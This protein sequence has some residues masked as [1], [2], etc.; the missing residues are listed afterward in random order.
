MVG[1]EGI[2]FCDK[3]SAVPFPYL[4]FSTESDKI[5]W[6]PAP[7]A[8]T[9]SFQNL[10]VW[11]EPPLQGAPLDYKR[12]SVSS[13]RDRLRTRSPRRESFRCVPTSALWQGRGVQPRILAAGRVARVSSGSAETPYRPGQPRQLCPVWAGAVGTYL[14]PE[15]PRGSPEAG[16][17]EAER[18]CWVPRRVAVPRASWLRSRD[19]CGGVQAEG[20]EQRGSGRSI[21][22][23]GSKQKDL[24]RRIRA[25]GF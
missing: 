6:Q 23:A 21:Q 10:E 9:E 11:R 12:E 24:G 8:V 1:W 25:A 13:P 18:S 22:A 19:P 14:P 3:Q 4:S 15:L 2:W 20:S 17:P 16:R 7:G 5:T